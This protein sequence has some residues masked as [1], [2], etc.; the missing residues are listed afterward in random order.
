MSRSNDCYLLTDT[1][2]L[3]RT[4]SLFFLHVG[5]LTKATAG[6]VLHI[7]AK[8]NMQVIIRRYFI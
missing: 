2:N 7:T 1:K 4:L 5:K 8:M 3:Y 6:A